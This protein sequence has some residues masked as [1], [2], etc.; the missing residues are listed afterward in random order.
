MIEVEFGS[1]QYFELLQESAEIAQ[2][3]SVGDR[4]QVVIEGKLYK[5]VPEK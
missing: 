5:I 4:L 3:M 1:D 2:W